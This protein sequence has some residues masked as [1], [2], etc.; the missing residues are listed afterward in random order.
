MKTHRT[1][2]A[3]FAL[4][5]LFVLSPASAEDAHQAAKHGGVVVESG[6]HH[7]EIVAKDGSVEVHV[8][9]EDGK[10]EDIKDAKASAAVLSEGKKIDISLVPDGANALK[11]TGIFKAVKGTT[12]VVTLTMPGHQPEQSRIKLD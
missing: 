3:I 4:A 1:S 9:G 5:A 8:T 12:V 7:L 6:H 11:G 10:P 2:S